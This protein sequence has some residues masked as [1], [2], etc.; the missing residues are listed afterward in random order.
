M[1]KHSVFIVLF[2]ILTFS[3][4]ACY[5]QTAPKFD[6][7]LSVSGLKDSVI[8]RRD[9]R[10]IPYIEAKNEA[11]LYFAQGYV[12]AGDR[13]WQMDSLR[14][15]ARGQ[16]AEIFGKQALNEDMRWRRF[17]FSQI[18][19]ETL[20][21]MNP[22]LKNALE[23]YARGVN[24][25]IATLDK[26]KLP[27]EFQILQ[28][29]PTEWK[30][31]D[32]IVIGKILADGLSTTWY[33]D[34]NLANMKKSLPPEK[35]EQITNQVTE[36]D[37]VLFGKDKPKVKSKTASVNIGS[38]LNKFVAEDFLIR[39]KSLERTGF[40][41]EE[42]AASNNWV[43]SGKGTFDG[44]SLLANDPHLRA[45]AP[46]IWYLS[47]LSTPDMKVSGVTFPGVPGVVLGHN[48]FIAW[49]AT[50]VGPDVQDVYLEE[51]NDKGEYKTAKGWEKPAIRKE[52]IKVRTSVAK[53]DTVDEV[54]EVIE[55]K[56]GV[57]F[58]NSGEQKLSLKW[59]ARNS[60]NEEFEAFILL[61]KAKNWDEF[62]ESLKNY[63]GATQ[64]FVYSDVKGNIGW[65]VAGQIPLRRDGDGSMP[66]DGSTN[67]G[68]WIGSIPFDELPRLYNP[69]S[70]FI[71][72]ANQRIVGTDYKY[73][74]MTRQIAPPW[75]AKR[76]VELIN[77]N[78]KIS[79]N[80]V[81]D[82]QHDVFNFPLSEFAR[83]IVKRK[84]ASI[85]TLTILKGWDGKMNADSVG[86][87]IVDG[88]NNCVG[89]KIANDNKPAS[90]YL[91]IQNILPYA[92]PKDDK[93]WLPKNFTN[94]DELL[95]VCDTETNAKLADVKGFGADSSNWKW[96]DYNTADF[97][98]PLSPALFVGEQFKASFT[99]VGGS[100]QTP[101]VGQNVS[102]R[103]IAK[104]ANW[105]ETRHVIP[106][107][108]SG[109]P[110]SSHWKDQ[111]EYWRTG[112][113]V[114]FPFT[115]EA[116]MKAA[117]ETVLMVK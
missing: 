114:V 76:I 7:T 95:K 47:H 116:V 62:R 52:I 75:R 16:T 31:T 30:T 50:N 28:Y 21:V 71:V 115:N 111:F 79:M 53:T 82:I 80:D 74:Q 54:L 63:G 46:G 39:K 34:V 40:Y 55:T 110:Q 10:S 17:G 64:N 26:D 41:A 107:G 83:E 3:F 66:Y 69:P 32:T 103:F 27:I 22:N 60:V 77:S 93:L 67:K 56:N 92:I 48:E 51:F 81:S 68:D 117:K 43:I 15:V 42:L 90:S 37:V 2:S 44:N 14:R 59:T 29:Q 58:N 5:A 8:V 38:E 70:G 49:G 78:K 98:H 91:I 72:T 89:N 85:E 108:Q 19:E 106:L 24:A 57:V 13:L 23:N 33:Q 84:A 35:F 94:W 25:Y 109:N 4:T 101:N 11:D 45:T 9:E 96:G 100:S 105:D 99:G 86:A 6:K 12:T 18:A 1:K 73:P 97:F 36:Y 102:M 112:K 61:N 65:Q 113:A 87:T 88:I 104:P 20:K